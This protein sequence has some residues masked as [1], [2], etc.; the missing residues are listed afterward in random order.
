MKF[1]DMLTKHRNLFLV[2]LLAATLAVSGAA[3]QERLQ[4]NS[5]TVDIPVMAVSKPSLSPLETYR[6]QRDADA[7]ADI[8]ALER[9]IAQ[10]ALDSQTRDAAADQL[11]AIIAV[12]Q[13]Q[14]A[15]EGALANSSLAPCVAVLAGD[16]LT[17]VTEK[18]TITEKDS[19]LVLTLADAHAGIRPENVRIITAE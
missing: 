16:A 6:Q 3:N 11:Q 10:N 9:L 15:L 12:R 18:A 4:A 8:S 14:T 1:G 7:L 2:I 5:P 19:A 13:A 17:I